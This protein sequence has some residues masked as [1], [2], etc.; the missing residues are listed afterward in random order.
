MLG[1]SSL[2]QQLLASQEIFNSMELLSYEYG[3]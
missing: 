1:I 2:A 3:T